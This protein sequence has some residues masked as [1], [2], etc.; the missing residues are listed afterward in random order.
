MP[1]GYGPPSVR[2]IEVFRAVML[3]GGVT[4]A[5]DL[6]HVTQPGVSRTLKHL[7]LQL[8]LR[9][10]ERVRGRLAP[11][12]EARALFDSVQQLYAGVRGVQ[13]FAAALR[14]GAH[15]SVRIA[16]SPSLA[17]DVVPQ[18]MAAVLRDRP[19]VHFELEVLPSPALVDAVVTGKADV[20]LCAAEVEHP[21]LLRRKLDQMRMV[22][23]VP[24]GHALQAR[25]WV[26]P[27]DVHGQPF[28]AFDAHTYQGRQV[29]QVFE[30]QRLPLQPVVRVRFARTA[31]SLVGAGIGLSF[32]DPLTAANAAP[33]EVRAVA[34]R[35][36]IFIPVYLLTSSARP[37]GS[38]SENFAAAAASALGQALRRAAGRASAKPGAAAVTPDR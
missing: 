30:R 18:A 12:A 2:Q 8:G 7:E 31:C 13:D 26:T 17:L 27:Q 35:P 37:L 15:T 28:V 22:C 24:P 21:G 34:L 32:V 20:G 33:A 25:R 4:G 6:L 5:A 3:A 14:E 1:A 38:A 16:C 23:V 19:R 9:L 36:G 11:T 29:S 10:F